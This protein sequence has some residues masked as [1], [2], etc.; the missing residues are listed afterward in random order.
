MNDG[1]P[2]NAGIILSPQLI[3]FCDDNLLGELVLF[4]VEFGTGSG[5]ALLVL[6][7]R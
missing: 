4:N 7:R 3:V 5:N 6:R 1:G 2:P